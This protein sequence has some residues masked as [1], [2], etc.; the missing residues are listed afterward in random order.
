MAN[1]TTAQRQFASAR[2]RVAHMSMAE[3][4]AHHAML[5]RIDPIEAAR[6]YDI[7]QLAEEHRRAWLDARWPRLPADPGSETIETLR[8]RRRSTA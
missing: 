6:R 4:V 5:N 3:L 2:T 1:A 7:L 8:R